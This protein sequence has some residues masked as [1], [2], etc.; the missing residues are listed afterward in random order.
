MKCFD[1]VLSNTTGGSE[2]IGNIEASNLQTA[3]RH[4]AAQWMHENPEARIPS[5][6]CAH[7]SDHTAVIRFQS[8]QLHIIDTHA[9]A[10]ERERLVRCFTGDHTA[11]TV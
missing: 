2:R 6:V 8:H 4:L 11:E 9:E 7:K 10:A 1:L 3:Q 5:M